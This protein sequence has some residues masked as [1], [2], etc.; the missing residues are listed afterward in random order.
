MRL[1]TFPGPGALWPWLVTGAFAAIKSPAG[2]TSAARRLVAG[3]GWRGPESESGRRRGARRS[4][5]GGMERLR[6]M[7]EALIFVVCV[8]LF[9]ACLVGLVIV[10]PPA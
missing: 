1:L 10:N 6:E 9:V 4:R 5:V 8:A 7:R 3:A 2:G